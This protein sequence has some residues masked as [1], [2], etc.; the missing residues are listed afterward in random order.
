MPETK[1]FTVH[2][3]TDYLKKFLSEK[4]PENRTQ[5]SIRELGLSIFGPNQKDVFM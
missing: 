3:L 2:E 1:I 5:F 4:D